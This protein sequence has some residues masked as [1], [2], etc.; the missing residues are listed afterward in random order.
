MFLVHASAYDGKSGKKLIVVVEQ[1][2]NY[3][4]NLN[5]KISFVWFW[6][7][8]YNILKKLSSFFLMS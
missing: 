4:R 5:L 7:E 6:S 8:F 3:N 1:G 2:L